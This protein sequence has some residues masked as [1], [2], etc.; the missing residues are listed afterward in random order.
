MVHLQLEFT[1]YY[2]PEIGADYI[3]KHGHISY[4]KKKEELY[5]RWSM[6]NLR[7]F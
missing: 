1:W 5:W 7:H 4:P 6:N 3:K 2:G